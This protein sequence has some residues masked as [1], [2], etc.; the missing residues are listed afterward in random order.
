[1]N[2]FIFLFILSLASIYCYSQKGLRVSINVGPGVSW[3]GGEGAVSA[4]TYYLSDA[5]GVPS[6]IL[7]PFGKRSITSLHLGV[8]GIMDINDVLAISLNGMYE[9]TGGKLDI[10]KA[11]TRGNTIDTNGSFTRSFRFISLNPEIGMYL[12]KKKVSLLAH[13]GLDYAFRIENSE[14]YV[15][16]DN[17]GNKFVAENSGGNEGK[18][19]LRITG[20]L[21]FLYRRWIMDITYKHGIADLWQNSENKAYS[22]LFVF[23][24]GFTLLDRS[25]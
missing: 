25:F 12:M 15:F 1:M 14:K 20:G 5:P 17:A 16:Y 13:T 7:E 24:L 9:I 3:F 21:T 6:Y 18:N 4:S 10:N 19:D 23:R 11:V 22:R 2:K 8:R